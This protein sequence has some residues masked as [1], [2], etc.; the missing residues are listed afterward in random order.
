MPPDKRL[1]NGGTG[2]FTLISQGAAL[3]FDSRSRMAIKNRIAE[4]HSDMTAWRRQIHENPETAFEEVKTSELVASKLAAFGVEVHRGLAGTGVVGVLR[5]A[6]ADTGRT[7]ALRADMDALPMQEANDFAHASKVPGKM[8]A[9]GHDGHTAMLLGAARY[10]AETRNFS[11]TVNFIFQPAEEGAGG[12]QRMVQE[13]LFDKFPCE[14]IFG[15][16]N[17][18][19]LP[20]GTIAVKTGP[21]M[22]GADRFDIVVR[23]RGGH[24]ALPHLG[25]DP[26]V[27]A[28]HLVLALQ[29]L[30]SRAISPVECGV[31]SVTRFEAGTAYNI[32]PGEVKLAGTIRALTAEIRAQ[33]EAGLRHMVETLPPTFG[34][35]A[36]LTY[37]H[38]YPPTVNHAE[39][40][41]IAVGIAQALV[42][43]DKVLTEVNPSMGAE[44]FSYMLNERP[45][46]YIWVGQGGSELGCLLHNT[47][48]D[49]NDE[50]LPLGAS[51]WANLVETVLTRVD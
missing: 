33:L 50:I 28:S 23:G 12:G 32:I 13:G 48:Y 18:P 11:G 14:M 36:E 19:E 46:T 27:A 8:H 35:S 15:M 20:P 25:V 26:I 22:A 16:H 1:S 40:S 2:G 6:G 42:G 43:P 21:V 45:G 9:C 5:G 44:D 3:P 4:F 41:R 51:Y 47:R 38:G 37:H 30:V 31:V 34:A 24:A 7:I 39:P 29:T 49:F 17:W 10:L